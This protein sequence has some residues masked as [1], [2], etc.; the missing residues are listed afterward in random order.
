MELLRCIS[1]GMQEKTLEIGVRR[2]KHMIW[3][4]WDIPTS[5]VRRT[6]VDEAPAGLKLLLCALSHSKMG[7][8]FAHRFRLLCAF[9]ETVPDPRVSAF[10]HPS[11]E[12]ILGLFNH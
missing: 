10:R 11:F 9:S 8:L 1:S 7:I 12:M 4:F 2:E 6:A 3:S 5:P